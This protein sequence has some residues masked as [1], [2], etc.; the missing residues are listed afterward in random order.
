[1]WLAVATAICFVDGCASVTQVD[2]AKLLTSITADSAPDESGETTDDNGESEIPIVP[3]IET[4][5]LGDDPA[6]EQDRAMSA[7]DVRLSDMTFRE[8]ASFRA[9]L[10]LEDYQHFYDSTNLVN[11]TVGFAAGAAMANTHFDEMVGHDLFRENF[12]DIANEDVTQKL[13]QPGM[14]G[15][16]YFILPAIGTAALAQPWLDQSETWRPLGEWGDRSARAILTG[17]PLVLLMQRVTGASRPNESTSQSHWELLQDNNGVSGHAFVGAVPFL[18]LVQMTDRPLLKVACYAGSV[19][20][21]I[22]RINDE[23]HYFSQVFL[24]WYIALLATHSVHQ[25]QTG[26]RGLQIFPTFNHNGLGIMIDR[27]F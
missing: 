22:S 17:G 1:M 27:R 20:P 12:V 23:R 11:L 9:E 3:Q 2:E 15:D 8:Q 5:G 6:Q 7:S 25:T 21:A 18:A 4:E 16:G 19:L 26:E 14:L 10:L 24:G 13:H